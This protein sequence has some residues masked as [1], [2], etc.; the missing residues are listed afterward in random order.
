MS[1]KLGLGAFHKPGAGFISFWSGVFIGILAVLMLIQYIWFNKADRTEKGK[2]KINW[3]AIT[4]TLVYFLG[5]ILILEYIGFIIATILFV[6]IILKSIEKKGWFLAT[7]VS[8]AMTLASYY[9]FKVWLQSELPK[10]FL[11]F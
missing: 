1:L 9:V 5:Y 6:G 2:E 8:L 3:K 7:W 11:G 4:L 10:G